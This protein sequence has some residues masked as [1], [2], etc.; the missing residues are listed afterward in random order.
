MRGADMQGMIFD[1]QRFSVH[2]GPGIRTTVF[3]KGCPLRCQWCHNPEGLHAKAQL[4]YRKE[5][6]IGCGLCGKRETEA[7]AAR[8]PSGALTVCGK[9]ITAQ[10]IIREVMKDSAFYGAEGGVTLSGGECLLQPDFAAEILRL[11]KENGITTAVDTCGYVPWEAF[12]KVMD[13]CDLF[14]YDIKTMDRDRHKKYTGVY[15][16]LIHENLI[17]LSQIDKPVWIRVPVIPGVND[18]QEDILEI[19]HFLKPLRNIRNITLIPYHTL[20]R[21]KYETLGLVCAY[22]AEPVSPA[23]AERLEQLLREAICND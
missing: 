18:S 21:S 1:V 6:C 8:C 20:G 5:L 13:A 22:N 17:R 7:D 9:S 10:E 14:L 15:P 2:D 16:E 12:E 3:F 4:Q 19:A 23:R 11:A